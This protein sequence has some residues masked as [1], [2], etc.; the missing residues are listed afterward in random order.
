M[1]R[2]EIPVEGMRCEGCARSLQFALQRLEGVHD[3]RADF[4]AGRVRLSL[5]RE[6]VSEQQ[7]RE[8]IELCGFRP[9]ERAGAG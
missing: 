4:A 8:T 6:R 1:T 9:A 2:I 5:D 3:A 7:V